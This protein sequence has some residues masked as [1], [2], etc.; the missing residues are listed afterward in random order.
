M[1]EDKKPEYLIG[2]PEKDFRSIFQVIS[3]FFFRSRV[4]MPVQKPRAPLAKK[5]RHKMV[6]TQEREEIEDELAYRNFRTKNDARWEAGLRVMQENAA[7]DKKRVP[8]P[9]NR[10]G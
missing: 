10:V 5:S 8:Q 7:R 4:P 6:L 3:D 1:W 9:P 2:Y